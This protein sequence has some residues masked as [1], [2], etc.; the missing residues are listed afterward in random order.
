M[1]QTEQTSSS[2]AA[3]ACHSPAEDPQAVAGSALHDDNNWSESALFQEIRRLR[4]EAAEHAR[5]ATS[6]TR[7]LDALRAEHDRMLRD[8]TGPKALA[9]ARQI[10]E[11]VVQREQLRAD[12][13]ASRATLCE[14][15]KRAESRDAAHVALERV[16]I[17][18]RRRLA[19]A[20]EHKKMAYQCENAV[21]ARE[22]AE[23]A[24]ADVK[25]E[26]EEMRLELVAAQ[27]READVD[28]IC[29]ERDGLKT[30]VKTLE[31]ELKARDKLIRE[32]DVERSR[33]SRYLLRY[34]NELHAKELKIHNLSRLVHTSRKAKDDSLP[35]DRVREQLD[36]IS[37]EMPAD[38]LDSEEQVPDDS[39][40][41]DVL[42]GSPGMGGQTW[43]SHSRMRSIEYQEDI[44]SDSQSAEARGRVSFDI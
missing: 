16:C 6:A 22:V 8:T 44:D 40:R 4:A 3:Q 34:E 43:T 41:Q 37:E 12:L 9:D 21:I 1:M 33:V 30:R 19:V 23:A 13:E 17:D 27:A 32:A 38:S 15:E 11:L 5:A 35:S 31:R 26:I 20:H 24:L 2:S 39:I 36:D 28:L 7:L 14:T 29:A 25:A 42:S 18:L 10:S